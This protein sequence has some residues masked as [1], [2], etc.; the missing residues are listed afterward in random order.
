MIDIFII[1]N[2]KPTVVC[3]QTLVYPEVG[4]GKPPWFY[5]PPVIVLED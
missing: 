5:I 4:Y 1:Q 2:F 3:K